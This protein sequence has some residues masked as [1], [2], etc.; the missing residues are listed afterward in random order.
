MLRPLKVGA[1]VI[2]YGSQERP[3]LNGSAAS[4]EQWDR[5]E[6]RWCVAMAAGEERVALPTDNVMSAAPP[7][8]EAIEILELMRAGMQ[9]SDYVSNARSGYDVFVDQ[10][11]WPQHYVEDL[12]AEAWRVDEERKLIGAFSKYGGMVSALF[13]GITECQIRMGIT[14]NPDNLLGDELD[15]ASMAL[16]SYAIDTDNPEPLKVMY[17]WA[18]DYQVLPPGQPVPEDAEFAPVSEYAMEIAA[19]SGAFRCLGFL[20]KR[21]EGEATQE[22]GTEALPLVREPKL[23]EQRV[24]RARSSRWLDVASE[25]GKHM[26]AQRVGR[27]MSNKKQNPVTRSSTPAL[28]RQLDADFNS[29]DVFDY[30]SEQTENR[31][32]NEPSAPA[33]VAEMLIWT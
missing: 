1:R 31:P 4:L 30:S 14:E 15:N 11:W 9:I 5:V 3:D 18:P 19:F 6:G 27:A 25:Y 20:R 28:A 33:S 21:N 32:V 13:M 26:I 29:I 12:M 10:L 2:V 16:F 24:Q 7:D 23:V 22:A 8:I 17:E